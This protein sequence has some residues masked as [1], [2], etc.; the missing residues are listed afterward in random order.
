MYTKRSI[1]LAAALCAA[2]FTVPAMADPVEPGES[3]NVRLDDLDLASATGQAQLDRRIDNAAR[4]VC[5]ADI[6]PTGYLTLHTETR[7]CLVAAKARAD[8]RVAEVIA[9]KQ[10]RG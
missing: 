6:M 2:G 8:S 5:R 7:K 10:Q 3:I 4:K 1:A 9:L